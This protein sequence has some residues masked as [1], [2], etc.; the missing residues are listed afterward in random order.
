MKIFNVSASQNLKSHQIKYRTIK[1][2]D[3]KLSIASKTAPLSIQITIRR[4]RLV[5][6]FL[7]E[8][9]LI[10]KYSKKVFESVSSS[11]RVTTSIKISLSQFIQSVNEKYNCQCDA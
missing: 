7:Y 3:F 4:H 5:P 8:F 9:E 11:A 2:E 1:K 6:G 10:D